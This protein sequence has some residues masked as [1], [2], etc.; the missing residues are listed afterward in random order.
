[1]AA[2]SS[3]RTGRLHA[4]F[5]YLVVVLALVVGAAANAQSFPARPDG[6]IL[7]Q[8]DLLPPTEEAA[9]DTKLRDYNRTT[10]RAVIVATVNSLD[11]LDE[12]SYARELAQE[13]GVGGAETEQGVLMLVAPNER[14]VFISTARGVQGTLTD[15]SAGRIVRNTITPAFRE[16]NF[17]EGISAGVDQIIER[18][19][20]DPAEAA[21]I[22]EAEAAAEQTRQREG[23]FPFGGLIW[24]GFIF[25]FFILPAMRGGKRR[26]YRRRSSPWGSAARDIMLWEAGKSIARG[27]DNDRGGW[28][29]GGLGGGGGFGGGGFGGFGGGGGGFNGGGAGGGW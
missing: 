14:R 9:L 24:L 22:D 12:E 7:D 21:A 1:M 26:R 18:L 15:I 19:N 8:A 6:P 11:G 20:M 10:G 29:G 17:A 16:G 23:G 3:G 25:F 5:A 2:S 4:W 27:L 28:G 13:W